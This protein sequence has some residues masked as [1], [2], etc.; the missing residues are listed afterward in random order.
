MRR[1]VKR[2][3]TGHGNASEKKVGK[4][5]GARMQPASGA[6]RSAKGDMKLGEQWLGEAK[7]TVNDALKLDLG[8][9]NKITVEA[10]SIGRLP[11][12]SMSFVMADG[13]PRRS[14]EWVAVPLE[15]FKEL[16]EK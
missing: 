9:L 10:L 6:M 8:F 11:F 2:G 1:A 5:L 14:G 7:S 16:I 15:V 12:L 3:S 4:S 13:S